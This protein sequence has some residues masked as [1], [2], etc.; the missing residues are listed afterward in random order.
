MLATFPSG[1][2]GSAVSQD[3]LSLICAEGGCLQSQLMHGSIEGS[4]T[5]ECLLGVSLCVAGGNVW[6]SDYPTCL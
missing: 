2:L 6:Q 4:F 1:S 5:S 3:D